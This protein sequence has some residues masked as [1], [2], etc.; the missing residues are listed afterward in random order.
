VARSAVLGPGLSD[1]ARAEALAF[2]LLGRSGVVTRDLAG[3]EGWWGLAYPAL[4]RL[5]LRGTVRRGYFVAG[6]AGLQYALPEAVEQ[7]RETHTG[8]DDT[9]V[10]VNASDPVFAWVGELAPEG[11]RWARVPSTTVAWWRGQAVLLAED[12]GERVVTAPDAPVDVIRRA[13]EAYLR[14]PNAPH[15]LLITTWNGVPTLGSGIQ[16]L[17][18]DVGF[19]RTPG[20]LEWWLGR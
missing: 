5:E 16:G 11:L 7:L 13:L 14:R 8:A 17:L 10:V 1:E 20:G 4:Q 18:Q 2:H 6:L 9:V 12:N 3:T 15:R 19:Q